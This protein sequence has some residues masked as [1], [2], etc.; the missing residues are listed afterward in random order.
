MRTIAPVVL[1]LLCAVAAAPISGGAETVRAGY[2]SRDL[3]YLP[4]FVAQKRGFAAKEG[5]QVD[6]VSIGRSDVQ[7]QALVTGD[8]DFANINADGI[9]IWNERSGANLK[10]SLPQVLDL[11]GEDQMMASADIPH[12]EARERSMDIVRG[13]TDVSETAKRKI[14]GANAERFYAL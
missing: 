5:L 7:L 8:L 9:I 2:T 12:G 10:T 13:R 11:L 1:L 3:N 14:L 6:L 4:F